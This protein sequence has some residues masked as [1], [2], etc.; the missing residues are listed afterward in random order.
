MEWGAEEFRLTLVDLPIVQVLI[1]PVGQE[2]V[3][4]V[5]ALD[6]AEVRVG[7]DAYVGVL[8][9]ESY[10]L[11]PDP[12]HP[13]GT[14]IRSPSLTSGMRL[15]PVPDVSVQSPNWKLTIKASSTDAL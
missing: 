12:N 1:R 10:Q 7:S 13:D 5:A 2:R 14:G 9:E 8:G 15:I 4:I 11:C 6:E 3:N